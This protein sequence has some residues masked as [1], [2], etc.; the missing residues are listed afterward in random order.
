V[1]AQITQP[2]S[3]KGIEVDTLEGRCRGRGGR[4]KVGGGKRHWAKGCS[5][6]V[7]IEQTVLFSWA[8]GTCFSLRSGVE[9]YIYYFTQECS[10]TFQHLP[11][12][13]VRFRHVPLVSVLFFVWQ[14]IT[15]VT[16]RHLL[17][18][19]S[20]FQH[21]PACSGRFHDI[22]WF[23]VAIW[24][25]DLIFRVLILS[26]LQWIIIRFLLSNLIW[27]KQYLNHLNNPLT[28]LLSVNCV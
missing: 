6:D 23:S 10:R 7:W 18:C 1:I 4:C 14:I 21:V 3:P 12:Y 16:F 9:V 22:P 5:A 28:S 11:Q 2:I 24:S 26:Y 19:S 20:T 13:S 15:F 27:I 17:E 25:L 8:V